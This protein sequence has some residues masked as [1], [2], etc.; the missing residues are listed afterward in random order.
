MMSQAYS[1]VNEYIQVCVCITFVNTDRLQVVNE[2]VTILSN[3]SATSK[4]KVCNLRNNHATGWYL[5]IDCILVT[6]AIL[7]K[8][9]G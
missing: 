3:R 2:P 9:W 5:I 6:E 4:L 1:T 8:H 7:Y